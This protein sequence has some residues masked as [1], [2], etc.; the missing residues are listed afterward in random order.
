VVNDDGK[1]NIIKVVPVEK[2]LT[3][4]AKDL[5]AEPIKERS[6]SEEV[7]ELVAIKELGAQLAAGKPVPPQLVMFYWRWI[8]GVFGITLLKGQTE[9]DINSLYEKELPLMK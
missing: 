3:E 5:G 7:A 6:R 8:A 9:A 4:A 1:N 2:T